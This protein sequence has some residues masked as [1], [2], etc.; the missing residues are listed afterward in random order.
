[1]HAVLSSTWSAKPLGELARRRLEDL[2]L[3]SRQDEDPLVGLQ[4]V[5]RAHARLPGLLGFGQR[6]DRCDLGGGPLLTTREARDDEVVDVQQGS[7][8]VRGRPSVREV[9]LRDRRNCMLDLSHGPK[10]T[11]ARTSGHLQRR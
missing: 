9:R 3:G 1:M 8:G 6:L 4:P 2:G 5:E 10:G 7:D 11:A